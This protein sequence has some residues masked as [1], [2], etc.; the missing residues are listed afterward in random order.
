MPIGIYKRTSEQL[1]RLKELSHQP[2]SPRGGGY[3]AIHK[4]LVKHY[5]RA[6]KCENKYCKS[7]KEY[8]T[9]HYALLKGKE[10]KHDRNNYI[11]L[12]P[13]CH[14]DY[15]IQIERRIKQSNSLRGKKLTKQHKLNIAKSM[16]GKNLENN[17]AKKYGI[18]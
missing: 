3:H 1:K 15:D 11:M 7:T 4:W 18:K 13:K 17:N 9:Y 10:H 6:N 12:C 16:K 14:F 8:K 5:G 2:R